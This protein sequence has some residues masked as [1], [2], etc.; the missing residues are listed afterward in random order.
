ML[1]KMTMK[2]KCCDLGDHGGNTPHSATGSSW[3]MESRQMSPPF[4]T[5]V[6]KL[7]CIPHRKQAHPSLEL[8]QNERLPFP[9]E[10]LVY[11]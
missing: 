6:E 10:R 9:A 5:L 7:Q 1:T 4:F 3:E 11:S 8:R 2:A